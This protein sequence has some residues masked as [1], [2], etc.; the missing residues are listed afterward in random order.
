MRVCH[1]GMHVNVKLNTST[2][3]YRNQSI[4]P[5][6]H[7]DLRQVPLEQAQLPVAE[8]RH[9]LVQL[10]QRSLR[11]TVDWQIRATGN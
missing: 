11:V 3:S 2:H 6:S 5:S 4:V 7:H 10:L 1:Y 8:P 9:A